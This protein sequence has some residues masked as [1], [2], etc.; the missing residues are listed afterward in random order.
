MSF[1][2]SKIQP[3]FSLFSYLLNS[4]KQNRTFSHKSVM[5]FSIILTTGSTPCS[6]SSPMQIFTVTAGVSTTGGA[7]DAGDSFLLYCISGQMDKLCEISCTDRHTHTQCICK[8]G[9]FI[10]NPSF[11]VYF[12]HHMTRRKQSAS[13]LL[14]FAVLQNH[15]QY[16]FIPLL[17]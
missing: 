5:C 9:W 3:R 14:H 12:K 2:F 10:R 16:L 13:D 17:S 4:R 1:S 8:N 11:P 15:C 7:P 6:L